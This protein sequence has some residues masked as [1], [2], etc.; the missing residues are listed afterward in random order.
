[1]LDERR[2]KLIGVLSIVA[3][4]GSALPSAV[5]ADDDGRATLVG[6]WRIT[7]FPESP[8]PFFSLFMFNVGNTM[9]E[10][11]GVHSISTVSGVWKKTSGR[12]TFALTSEGFADND[13]DGVFETRF[14]GRWTIYLNGDTLTGTFTVDLLNLDGTPVGGP[15]A[16]QNASFI[17]TRMTVI[18]E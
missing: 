5:R 2:R 6:T 3:L 16:V 1:M 17:G 15:P 9:T 12:G 10:R 7:L 4:L 18:P 14:Q 13:S 8:N 11:I